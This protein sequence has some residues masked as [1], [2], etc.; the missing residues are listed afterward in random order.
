MRS[1]VC[2]GPSSTHEPC[3][4]K[5]LWAN[6]WKRVYALNKVKFLEESDMQRNSHRWC[7]HADQRGGVYTQLGGSRKSSPK[8]EN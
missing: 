4:A 8:K 7:S 3:R 5:P 2:S 1:L 6:E